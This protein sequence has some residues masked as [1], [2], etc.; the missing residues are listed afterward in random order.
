M[1]NAS[2]EQDTET[3]T[4][5]LKDHV[6]IVRPQKRQYHIKAVEVLILARLGQ[7]DANPQ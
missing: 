3:L 2:I 1:H 4:V 6:S 5:E 7:K